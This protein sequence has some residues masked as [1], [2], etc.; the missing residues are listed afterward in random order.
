[1]PCPA[2]PSTC[3]SAIWSTRPTSPSPPSWTS[4]CSSERT[5]VTA[6]TTDV[7]RRPVL[8]ALGAAAA[9][10]LL[11]GH[12]PYRQW[13]VFRKARLVLLVSAADALAVRLAQ[14]LVGLYAQRLPESRATVARARDSNDLVRLVASKQLEIAL[15]REN[16]AHAVL[17]GAEPF[18]DNGRVEL[19]TLAA[20]GD[21]LLV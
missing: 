10:L 13:E 18:S 15:L 20:L 2:S 9:V 1:M 12:S 11:G 6:M 14:S 5:V 7:R 8:R 4:A 16:Q 3:A 19:R 21:H 17:T